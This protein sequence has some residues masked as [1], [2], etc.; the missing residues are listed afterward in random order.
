MAAEVAGQMHS[1]KSKEK[2]VS[3][4]RTGH[5]HWYA[6]HRQ[7]PPYTIKEN[8]TKICNQLLKAES[9]P[10]WDHR[11]SERH[12][13]RENLNHSQV[14]Y[15]PYWLLTRKNGKSERESHPQCYS[16]SKVEQLPLQDRYK[17]LPKVFPKGTKPYSFGERATSSFTLRTQVKTHCSWE[18]EEET[19]YLWGRDRKHDRPK[20]LEI[21]KRGKV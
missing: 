17:I 2:Q 4:G 21:L 11:I 3:P 14:L 12:R 5:N 15:R 19:S 13:H 8:S 9:G 6:W 1:L 10:A 16:A 7:W 20:P 18:K